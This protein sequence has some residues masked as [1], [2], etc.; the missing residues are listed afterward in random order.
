VTTWADAVAAAHLFA[1]DPG[2]TGVAVRAPAGPMRERWLAVLRESLPDDATLRRVPLNI[3]D[4]RLLGGLDLAATLGAGRPVFSRGLLAEAGDGVLMFAMAERLPA[5]TAARLAAALDQGAQFGTLALDEGA[6]ADERPPPGLMDRLAF[7]VVLDDGVPEP[8]DDI[9]DIIA[10]RRQL[11]AV[12]AGDAVLQA[13][14]TTAA[15]L[16][17]GSMRAPT[18]ALRAARAAAALA[19][20]SEVS[21]EDAALAARL[22]LAPRATQLPEPPQEEAEPQ[23]Q[24]EPE[25]NADDG[26]D[27]TG[28]PLEDRI[29]EATQAAIPAGLLA[30]LQA[31]AGR[32]RTK[33]AG[34]AGALHRS[35]QRGRP[36]GVRPGD[37]RRGLRLN[38]IETLRAAAP[39]QTIRRKV[40]GKIE[41]RSSDFRVTHLKQRSATTTIFVVDASG[42]A[43]LNRLAEAKGAV[44][45]LLA[46][47]Y[48]RRDRVAVLAFRGRGAQLLLPPTRSLVRAK[49]SLA[50]LPGGGGTPL[51]AGIDAGATL[52][53]DV[54]RRGGTATLV[55]LTDGRANVARDGRGNRARADEEALA[56]ARYLREIG[57]RV[58]LVDTSPRPS[59][60]N[61]RLAMQMGARYLPLP[62]ADAATL[63]RT[64]QAAR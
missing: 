43:A 18:L 33:V 36:A 23:P 37:P 21:A 55:L 34:K 13:L 53:A 61:E 56:A 29:L 49:R 24:S 38:L 46:E 28:K 57:A 7:A 59:A 60:P 1:V 4:D 16:G 58:L 32:D 39:W 50:G 27:D 45:L 47:C 19:G 62:Y 15:A 35:S 30:Q 48:V 10:A 26:P 11:P 2:G 17:V 40:A 51:A 64:V 52:A 63:S 3:A 31:Q 6:D 20:R 25:S 54:Q 44:E 5:R 8:A 42:S 22:V 41:I 9:P 12:T 14:C